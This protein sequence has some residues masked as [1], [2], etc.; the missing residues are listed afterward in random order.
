[1]CVRTAPDTN[2]MQDSLS[3]RGKT[4]FES[5]ENVSIVKYVF[6]DKMIMRRYDII[7]IENDDEATICRLSFSCRFCI[8]S[9]R[10]PVTFTHPD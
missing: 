8:S 3:D 6:Y 10:D 1:M 2:I 4:Y 5:T 7:L 9:S